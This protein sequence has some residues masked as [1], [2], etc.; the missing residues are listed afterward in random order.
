[1]SASDETIFVAG[2][3]R[4]DELTVAERDSC[5]VWT[6]FDHRVE[7]KFAAETSAVRA[8]NPSGV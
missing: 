1:V 6:T 4:E 5:F 7:G 3:A 8:E 2:V